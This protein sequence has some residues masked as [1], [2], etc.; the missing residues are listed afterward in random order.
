M[1]RPLR[2]R[3]GSCVLGPSG[4]TRRCADLRVGIDVH[5]PVLDQLWT[6]MLRRNR[7][8]SH[9]AMRSTAARVILAGGPVWLV[10]RAFGTQLLRQCP[11]VPAG[12]GLRREPPNVRLGAARRSRDSDCRFLSD[13]PLIGVHVLRTCF[14]CLPARPSHTIAPVDRTLL[15]QLLHW[16]P[17]DLVIVGELYGLPLRQEPAP[18]RIVGRSGIGRIGKSPGSASRSTD[19]RGRGDSLSGRGL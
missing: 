17:L 19:L 5:H 15:D 8:Q 6:S 1:A 14:P 2:V 16:P 4:G 13:C 18:R 7:G 9:P 3:L 10:A 12:A 11:G